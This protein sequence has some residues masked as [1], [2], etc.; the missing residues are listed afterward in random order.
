MTCRRGLAVLTVAL[1]SALILAVGVGG[2]A[3]HWWRLPL[4]VERPTTVTIEPGGTA[5]GVA[6]ALE[7]A[8]LLEDGRLLPWILRLRGEAKRLQA[9]EYGVAPG[10]TAGQL[11]TRMVN[12]E[13]VHHEFRILEGSRVADV[14]A[15]LRRQVRLGQSLAQARPET[16]LADLGL[17]IAAGTLGPGHGEGWFFP[18]TYQ[19]TTGEEDRALLLRAHAKMVAELSAAWSRRMPEL[20]YRSPYEALIAASLIEKE[21]SRAADRPHVSQVL[22]GRLRRNMR[23]QVDPTVIYGL[24]DAFDGDL[25]RADLR[26]PTPYNTYVH[27][28]L[29]PT[30]IALPGREALLAAVRPSGADYLYFV[31]RGDGSSQF[32]GTLA[33][34]NA[35]VRKFQL[36]RRPAPR[37]EA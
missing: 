25:R 4:S 6:G 37:E 24:G 7:A 29:P 3:V 11:L 10:E 23:L 33:E 34:H 17:D 36:N 35:A 8:G 2:F 12:G 20:P 13:V 19:F 30:P 1:A 15:A 27:R 22:V 16:L 26:R 21:T 14:L 5:F 32:S 31:A 18:D 28:G 9:G